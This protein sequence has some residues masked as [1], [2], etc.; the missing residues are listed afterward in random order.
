MNR[1]VTTL[2]GN[3]DAGSDDGLAMDASFWEPGGL[4]YRDGKLY[5]ADTNNHAIRVCDL[6]TFDVTTLDISG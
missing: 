1:A 5:V 6:D 2:F 3:G 4:S